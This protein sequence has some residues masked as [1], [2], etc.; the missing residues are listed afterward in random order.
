MMKIKILLILIITAVV[1][2]GC[3]KEVESAEMLN[4]QPIAPQIIETK[5]I[6]WQV[7]NHFAIGIAWDL[8]TGEEHSIAF[9]SILTYK[10]LLNFDLGLIDFEEV[11]GTSD[12]WYENVSPGIGISADL[13]GL[14]E[15]LPTV[16]EFVSWIPDV[17]GIGIGAYFEI[18]ADIDV[19]PIIYLTAQW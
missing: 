15:S 10:K 6:N 2:V 3:S 17:V 18:D 16:G 12:Q 7:F 8:G 5:S 19:I 11:K 13:L 14:M 9:I 4:P 1:I